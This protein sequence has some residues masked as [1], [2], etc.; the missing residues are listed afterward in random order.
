MVRAFSRT[1]QVTFTYHTNENKAFELIRELGSPEGL[2]AVPM[3]LLDIEGMKATLAAL[4]GDGYDIVIHNAASTADQVFYFLEEEQWQSVTQA[5]LN[6]FFYINKAFL[7]HM[8]SKRW[9]RILTM[10]S[11][12][13]EAGN[14]GQTN[15]AAAKGAL[16]AASKSLAKEVARKGVLVNVI[17]P[18]LIE[19]DMSSQVPL[20]EVL[21]LLPIGRLGQ[22][23]EVAKAALFL[24]SD[25]ASYICGTVLQV[26]GGLY[27]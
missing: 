16:I 8:I 1:H 6:S 23:E 15:Y 21:P 26:N 11:V 17:S 4:E 20:A 19:T 14:R 18:G 25:D 5:S 7:P 27:T 10:A 9:G 3:N 12:S 13:G 2:R 22:A 24:A